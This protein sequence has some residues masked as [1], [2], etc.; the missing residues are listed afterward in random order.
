MGIPSDSIQVGKTL[1]GAR[2][3]LDKTVVRAPADGYV[4]NLAL[5]KGARVSNLS[6]APVMAFIDTSSSFAAMSIQQID[7][8]Y[9]APGQKVE[10]T[11]KYLPG[12]VFTGK[13]E[14]VLQALSTGQVQVSGLAVTSKEIEAQPFVVRV[15]LDDT[16]VARSLPAGSV[17]TAAIFTERVKAAHIIR[18]VL[19][20]QEAILNYILPF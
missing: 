17:G 12:R 19:L 7:A 1:E 5:R 2:W 13:V 8:R 15:T 3:N 4:T 6:A 11:F 10:L 14:T 18:R 20:R 9:V 16:A